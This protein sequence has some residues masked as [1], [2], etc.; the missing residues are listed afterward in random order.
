VAEALHLPRTPEVEPLEQMV[1]TLSCQLALLVL[2]NLEQ[3]LPEGAAVVQTLLE[4]VE[5]LTVMDPDW[6]GPHR[7]G[8]RGLPAAGLEGG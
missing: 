8:T 3:L 2:D 1:A 6:R 7:S 4:R 5:T